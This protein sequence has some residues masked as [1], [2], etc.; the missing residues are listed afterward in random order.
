MGTNGKKRLMQ[1]QSI[2]PRVA[3][4]V[5]AEGYQRLE[6]LA[7]ETVQS[8][9]FRIEAATGVR[10]TRNGSKALEMLIAD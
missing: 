10:L 8:V 5:A 2:D 6:D 9:S 4:W 3:D 7:G 1:S